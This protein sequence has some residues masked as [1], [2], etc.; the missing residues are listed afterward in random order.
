MTKVASKFSAVESRLQ[1]AL[2]M[3]DRMS[4]LESRLEAHSE[5]HSR[6]NRLESRL[7]THSEL[8][9]RVNR[10]EASMAPDPEQERLISRISAKLDG[11]ERAR[12]G[13]GGRSL[14]SQ[15]I[16]PTARSSDR[17]DAF[18]GATADDREG[19]IGY[20]Q[21]RI[22]KLKELRTRYEAEEEGVA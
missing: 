9:S 11:L 3:G 17:D 10:L 13:E 2:Q 4:Q 12:G 21:G 18:L 5:L 22:E 7:G 20:L 19:R 1:S 14:G 16:R 6:M 8:H 15:S